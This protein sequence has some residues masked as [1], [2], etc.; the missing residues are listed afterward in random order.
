M[1]QM[2]TMYLL[3]SPAPRF[4]VATGHVSRSLG[5]PLPHEPCLGTVIGCARARPR[6]VRLLL[7]TNPL[8]S[9]VASKGDRFHWTSSPFS[10]VAS[11]GDRNHWT[12]CGWTKSISHR[13]ETMVGTIA[14]WVLQGNHDSRA[15]QVVR[16][17]FRPS[18]VWT[19]NYPH[20]H[21]HGS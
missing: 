3:R 19:P 12:Y 6:S 11:E 1:F 17:G 15:S 13:F 4:G 20:I 16:N 8:F 10:L 7:E 18:T 2:G 5:A 9:P 14:G 21:Q